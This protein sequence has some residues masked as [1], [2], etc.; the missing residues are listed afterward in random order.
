MIKPAFPLDEAFRLNTLRALNLLDT[1]PEERFDRLTRM[2]RR[3]FG[4]T[5]A[6]VSLCLLYTSPSPRDRG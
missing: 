1:P 3:M 6:L 2:A 5:T 4:V